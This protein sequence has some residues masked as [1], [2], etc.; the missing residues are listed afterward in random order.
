MPTSAPLHPRSV[1]APT[2]RREA[3]GRLLLRLLAGG[4]LLPHG[5]G[6]L[7]G[8]FGGPGLAGFAAELGQFGLPAT[9]P[10]PGLI[11]SLQSALGLLVVLGLSTRPSALLASAFLGVTVALNLPGGWFWIG[12]GIEFPLFWAGVFIAVALL[13]PGRWSI[14]ARRRAAEDASS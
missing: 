2:R 11:A 13:G 12:G 3:A 4:W 5:L 14:D 9:H 6:K 1:A 8:W 10:W 7:F